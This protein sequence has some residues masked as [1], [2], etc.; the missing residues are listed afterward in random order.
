MKGLTALLVA[1]AA[2]AVGVFFWRRNKQSAESVWTTA[3]DAVSSWSKT[4]ADTAGEATDMVTEAADKGTSAAE[5]T[6]D[7]VESAVGGSGT[8][9]H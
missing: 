4:A 5:T 2:V 1:I 8:N 3:E 6:A 9:P 7:Q